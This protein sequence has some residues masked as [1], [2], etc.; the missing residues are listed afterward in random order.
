MNAHGFR[1]YIE[2][3]WSETIS[4]WKNPNIIYNNNT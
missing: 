4:L 1:K 2:V 3:L